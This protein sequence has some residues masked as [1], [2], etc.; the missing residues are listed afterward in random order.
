MREASLL[1]R[2]AG[3]SD[4]LC[5][6]KSMKGRKRYLREERASGVT[7]KTGWGNRLGEL[8]APLVPGRRFAWIQLSNDTRRE[9][10]A[11]SYRVVSFNLAKLLEFVKLSGSLSVISGD[12]A[13]LVWEVDWG[14]GFVVWRIFLS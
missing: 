5:Y 12:F 7:G 2:T 8:R 6:N 1:Q 13:F 14:G 9:R 10:T 4:V 11:R 3:A